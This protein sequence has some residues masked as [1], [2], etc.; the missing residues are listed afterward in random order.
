[1]EA[2]TP[3][4]SCWHLA[5]RPG[6]L[7]RSARVLRICLSVSMTFSMGLS[8]G[9]SGPGEARLCP[10]NAAQC[11]VQNQ[12]RASYLYP[13]PE[14][15]TITK[16]LRA[17]PTVTE[18]D[19]QEVTGPLPDLSRGTRGP[20]LLPKPFGG[21]ADVLKGLKGSNTY[22]A[23]SETGGK[24]G[25]RLEE[26]GGHVSVSKRGG[27]QERQSDPGEGASAA[28]AK[29][30]GGPGTLQRDFRPRSSQRAFLTLWGTWNFLDPG[31]QDREL[32]SPR[33]C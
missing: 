17:E 12:V 1:M 13:L 8:S 9:R 18:C 21:G 15:A 24:E 3:L 11:L 30:S 19:A 20:F 31:A 29:R 22:T 7:N 16:R 33:G 2:P 4:L 26:A 6:L 27:K 5:P 14:L 23:F 25:S 32:L 10:Q 28:R